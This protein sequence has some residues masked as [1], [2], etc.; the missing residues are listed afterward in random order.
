MPDQQDRAVDLADEA[1]DVL[2]V[3]RQAAQRVGRREDGQ[4]ARLQL[5]MTGAQNDASAKPPCTSTMVGT[6][7]LLVMA[8]PLEE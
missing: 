5:R 6:S 8:S 3:V 4:V 2:G 7:V 1:R